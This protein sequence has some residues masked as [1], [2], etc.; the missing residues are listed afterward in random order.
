[1][2]NSSCPLITKSHASDPGTGLSAFSF[3]TVLWVGNTSCPYYMNDEWERWLWSVICLAIVNMF[4]LDRDFCDL[5]LYWPYHLLTLRRQEK[6]KV[7]Y[8]ALW[9]FRPLMS[10]KIFLLMIQLQ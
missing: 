9:P 10:G 1:M 7:V 8:E 6:A 2:T 5:S 3:Y 4:S